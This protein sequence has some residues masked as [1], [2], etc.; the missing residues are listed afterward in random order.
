MEL[1]RYHESDRSVWVNSLGTTKPKLTGKPVVIPYVTLQQSIMAGKPP[2]R[3]VN[4]LG[5]I[6][7]PS[8]NL[9]IMDKISFLIKYDN[10]ERR[11]NWSDLIRYDNIERRNNWSNLIRYD[12]IERRHNWSD[13]A[14]A[15]LWPHL[16]NVDILDIQELSNIFVIKNWG[17]AIVATEG[18]PLPVC[19]IALW[20]KTTH[21]TVRSRYMAVKLI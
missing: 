7:A 10:I 4:P 19:W 1:Y 16:S 14:G 13:F 3:I 20:L 2:E 8:D 5:V 12:N 9:S 6:K 17:D 18:T 15:K 21:A 11:N